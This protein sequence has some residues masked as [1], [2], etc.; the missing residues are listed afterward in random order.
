MHPA[1]KNRP[2]LSLPIA[3]GATVMIGI[4]IAA[5]TFMS[6]QDY[7]LDRNML[8]QERALAAAEEGQARIVKDWALAWNNKPFGD[9]I[10]RDYSMADGSRAHVVTTKLN[11]YT[12]WVMSEGS[13]NPTSRQL[14]ARRRTNLL[15]RLNVP[16]LRIPGAVAAREATRATG[17]ALMGGDDLNPTGW[18]DCDPPGPPVPGIAT[19]S[20][21]DGATTGGC[22]GGVCITTTAT[23]KLGA[24]TLLRDTST[25]S[26][27]GGLN[28]DSL[29]AQ[30]AAAG[31]GMVINVTGALSGIGPT[32]N[33]D[34]SC[35]KADPRNW[36]DPLR[37]AVTPGKCEDYFPIIYLKSAP[38]YDVVVNGGRG[39][40]VMIVDGNLKLNGTF[41]WYGPIIVRGNFSTNGTV[42]STGVKVFGGVMAANLN[43]N[44]SNPSS[45]PCNDITGNSKVQFS[46]CAITSAVTKQAKAVMATRS[47]ADL[48]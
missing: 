4:I 20:V 3:M 22:A 18:T 34:G 25:F 45:S 32:Y 43:C 47:W 21:A 8:F 26:Q 12:Y 33:G 36:G 40:G 9:T 28:Y 42:S 27:Y 5:G 48:F 35:N 17:S 1:L 41:E 7:R 38:T 13:A 30:A 31:A 19:D 23:S 14:N 11:S 10:T 44:S 15:L 6:L 16:N 29:K 39:Q 24:D 2:G 37:N 46:R